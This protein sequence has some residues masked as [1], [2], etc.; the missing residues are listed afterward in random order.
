MKALYGLDE[1]GAIQR[2]AAEQEA[3]DLYVKIK[4]LPLEGLAGAWFDAE[5][6]R[7]HIA[8]SSSD[9]ESVV[10]RLGAVPVA[11]T[12]PLRE[13]EALQASIVN[14]KNSPLPVGII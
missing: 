14:E 12:W 7:L 1:E 4:S 10:A 6:Q 3:S 11:V 13:L 8:L 2:L 5:T 9:S